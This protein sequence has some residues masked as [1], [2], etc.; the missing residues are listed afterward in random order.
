MMNASVDE[1]AKIKGLLNA[2]IAHYAP[3]GRAN[4]APGSEQWEWATKGRYLRLAEDNYEHFAPNILFRDAKFISSVSRH[5]DHKNAWEKYHLRALREV[6]ALKPGLDPDLTH[7]QSP[8][9]VNAFGDHFLTDAF[10]SGHVINKAAVMDLFKANFY[11]GGKLS[12][13]GEQFLETVAKLA[14]KG[15]LAEK[16][17]VLETYDPKLLWWNP[18]IDSPGMFAKLLIGIANAEPDKVANLAVKALHDKLNEEGIEVTNGLGAAPW[19]LTGDG[20]LTEATL[21]VMQAAVKQ[22]VA[23][24]LD[25]A[26]RQPGF[27]PAPFL[28]RV[29]AHVPQLTQKSLDYLRAQVPS[30]IN[31]NSV[32]LSGASAEILHNEVDTLI[33]ELLQRKILK[34]A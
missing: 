24:I 27:A 25:P 29:W 26:A 7:N 33:S 34:P 15:K 18:N 5:G 21:L 9:I 32:W 4:P 31:T 22:S 30:F 6:A 12:K 11:S 8:L 10:S 23:N 2:D 28:A 1:L 13:A 14:F 20:H 17:S 19:R 16:F 3:G